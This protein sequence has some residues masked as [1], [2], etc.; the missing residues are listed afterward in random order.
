MKNNKNFKFY[1]IANN[2]DIAKFVSNSGVDRIFIDLE[3][4]GK[5][6]R[7]GHLDTWISRHSIQD[8]SKIRQALPNQ[9][10]LT[11]INPINENS[12]EEIDEAIKKAPEEEK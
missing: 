10:I 12:E 3:T 7:Q 11:R 2:V 9:H 1:M 5:K 6:E 8:I 4:L